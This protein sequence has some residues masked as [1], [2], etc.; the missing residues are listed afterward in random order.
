MK[1]GDVVLLPFAQADAV[2]KKRPAVLLRILPPFDDFLVC[3]VSRQLRHQVAGFDEVIADT[4]ADF[5]ASGLVETPL[6]RL[7]FLASLPAARFLG[8]IGYIAT[9]RHHRLLQRLARY[10]E[11]PLKRT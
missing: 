3:G 9:T 2:T 1:E 4:D 6:I 5:K 11:A 10:L 8:D 7:G